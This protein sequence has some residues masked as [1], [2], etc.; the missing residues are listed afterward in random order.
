MIRIGLALLGALSIAGCDVID[1]DRT[2]DPTMATLVGHSFVIN[3]DSFLIENYCLDEYT[4]TNCLYMQI[5]GG[6]LEVH[7][8]MS[9]PRVSLPKSFEDYQQNKD[10]Y[11]DS[12]R[13]R[14]I[15]H[16]TRYTVVAEIPKGTHIKITRIVS[17]AGGDQGRTWAVFGTIASF[18][19]DDSIQIGP[20]HLKQNGPQW[21]GS[22]DFEHY[23]SPPIPLPDFLSPV[24]G[25]L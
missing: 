23:N 5:A 20:G 1:Y 22:R 17:V 9:N 21:F 7:R 25:G 14:G 15:F 19:S 24:G 6:Y 10:S 11:G 16:S 4:T 12:L 3:K 2:S 13:D 8:V 18:G